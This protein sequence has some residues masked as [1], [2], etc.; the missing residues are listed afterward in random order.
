MPRLLNGA[1]DAAE[2]V[3]P[4]VKKEHQS[5]TKHIQPGALGPLKVTTTHDDTAF[6]F[7]QLHVLA[8]IREH[9]THCRVER[10]QRERNLGKS[11]TGEASREHT[12]RGQR[13]IRVLGG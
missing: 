7:Y 1:V 10:I 6:R 9:D 5:R 11:E 4:H 8:V 3:Q 12:A 2:H 13:R